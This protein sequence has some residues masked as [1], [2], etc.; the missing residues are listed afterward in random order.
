M[1]SNKLLIDEPRSQDEAWAFVRAL[2]TQM[3][4][5]PMV[6][7]RKGGEE[8]FGVA[9]TGLASPK[10]LTAFLLSL[11]AEP[12]EAGPALR[13]FIGHV[14][15]NFPLRRLYWHCPLVP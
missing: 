12:A 4:G 2:R 11:F 3:Y 8:L 13:L 6:A 15:W 5:L 14:F 10:N 7:F 1:G 9:S